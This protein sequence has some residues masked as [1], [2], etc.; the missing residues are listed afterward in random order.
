MKILPPDFETTS[1]NMGKPA[2]RQASSKELEESEAGTFAWFSPERVGITDLD[3]LRLHYPETSFDNFVVLYPR[4]G[5]ADIENTGRKLASAFQG[6][7]FAKSAEGAKKFFFTR[8]MAGSGFKDVVVPLLLGGL[9]IFSSLM[10]SIVDREREIFT[11]S[12]M[13]LSPPSVGVLFFAESAVYSVVGG[14][15]GYLLSQLV[16]KVLTFLGSRGIFHPPEMNFSSLASVL[17]ILIVMAVVMLSTIYP[18]LKAGKSANPGVARKWKMPPPTGDRLTFVFPF[19]VSEADFSGILSFIK[20]HFENHGD[21]TLGDFAAKDVGLFVNEQRKGQK[22]SLGISADISL[23]PFDLGIF[24]K[25][26]MY[27]KEFEIAGIDEVVV[28]L[29]RIGGTPAAWI[30]ANRNFANELRQQFLLWRSLP[31]ETVEHYRKETARLLETKS[32]V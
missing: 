3:S 11:Y 4:S 6:A 25:F 1:R 2:A 21:A 8:A 32:H 14:M 16:A 22:R 9:I 20:E 15:G 7:V 29:E 26:R 10:G 24:Q 18:A 30:R 13:G 17:T 19:T 12:A 27:S 28:E 5:D 31:I 23:A